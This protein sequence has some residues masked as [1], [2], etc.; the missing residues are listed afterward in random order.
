MANSARTAGIAGRCDRNVG[1][2]A[3]SG[4]RRSSATSKAR[5]ALR[6][7]RRQV[8]RTLLRDCFS[9]PVFFLTAGANDW[10]RL[11]SALRYDAVSDRRAC[12]DRCRCLHDARRRPNR[13]GRSSGVFACVH[14]NRVDSLY[15]QHHRWRS[16]SVS[17]ATLCD[18]ISGQWRK[19]HWLM[20]LFAALFLIRFLAIG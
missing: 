6:K 18:L 16:R 19:L 15:L 9:Y 2:R 8:W 3:A 14:H 5:Q 17:S 7:V 1:G 11:Q 12:I 20:V 10:R 4:I 13:M